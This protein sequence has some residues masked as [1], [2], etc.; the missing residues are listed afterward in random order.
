[1]TGNPEFAEK[2]ANDPK[3]LEEFRRDP[4]GTVEAAGY[5]LT[6]A[7]SQAISVFSDGALSD[8]ELI[9]RVSFLNY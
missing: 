6:E 8:G 9:T 5:T 4:K 7:E 2:M 3:L 1:M